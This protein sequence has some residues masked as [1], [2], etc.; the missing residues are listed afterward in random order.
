MVA[1]AIA[2][3]GVAMAPHVVATRTAPNG[4][5]ISRHSPHSLGRVIPEATAARLAEM[6]REVVVR[7]TGTG[8]A[9][10][11]VAV[12]GKT[13]TAEGGGGPHAWFIGFGPTDDPR[14]A[15]AVVVEGGGSG[16]RVAAPIA[17]RVIAAWRDSRG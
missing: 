17:A 8:A 10:G 4:S 2:N 11:E 9:V 12:A 6:M 5:V 3:D 13:G 15:V 16:G 7:G 1:A 14:I